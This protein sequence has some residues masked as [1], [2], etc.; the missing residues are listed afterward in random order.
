MEIF[1]DDNKRKEYDSNLIKEEKQLKPKIEKIEVNSVDAEVLKQQAQDLILNNRVADAIAAARRATEINGADPYSWSTL[2][3]ADYLWGNINDAIYE[4]RKAI[5]LAPNND[6]FYLSLGLIYIDIDKID[7]AIEC[8]NRAMSINPEQPNNKYLKAILAR[9]NGDFDT[10]ISILKEIIK[11]EPNNY[12]WRYE[13]C[14]N[15]LCKTNKYN[16]INNKNISRSRTEEAIKAC[17]ELLNDANVYVMD[18]QQLEKIDE[19][20]KLYEDD[21]KKFFCKSCLVGAVI[22]TIVLFLFKS[23]LWKISALSVIVLVVKFSYISKW[24]DTR[25]LFYNEPRTFMDFINPLFWMSVKDEKI[26]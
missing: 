24:K 21:L 11:V 12:S 23:V 20:I 15:L 1:L 17:L 6:G 3:Y 22:P 4:F 18:Q 19:S 8:A 16:Y 13:L 26:N 7:L 10:A 25:N 5:S 2:G 14:D 9:M